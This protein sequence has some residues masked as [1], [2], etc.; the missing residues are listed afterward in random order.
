MGA[1]YMHN[2]AMARLGIVGLA[3]TGK[4]TLFN[5]LTGLAAPAAAHPYSTVEPN[6]GVANV[7]DERLEVAA[8]LEGSAR[9]VHAT[10]E[11]M[12][13]PPLSREGGS[14]AR[15]FM[16]RLRE[17]E[18]L[19]L[20]LRAF[21]DPTVPSAAS[22][23]DPVAQ[24]EELLLEL[25]L[26]DHEVFARRSERLAK[27]AAADPT[28]RSA[29]RAVEEA[30]DRL[31]NGEALRTRE[32]SEE[33]LSAFRDL[34]PLTL[35]PAVWVINI[36]EGAGA[37][38]QLVESVRAVVPSPDVV[39]AISARLE[40]EGA[41]LAPEERAELYEGLGLGEGALARMVQA[42]YEGLGLISFYTVG[43]KESRAW[44]VRAG[45]TA[46]EAAG[47]I[48]SDLERGFIRVE[49]ATLDA[50]LDAGGWDNAK[51]A[52]RVRVEGK[53]Y[54][55]QPDDVLVVRFSV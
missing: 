14:P 31:S 27:E 15:Q 53:G 20:V 34:A 52:G 4:T 9:V 18:A 54:V 32:W 24:A 3:N 22:G 37:P 25:A 10:L 29:G 30:A 12:D 17:M 33:A 39:V 6:V 40:E 42:A 44:T 19:V 50:V 55:V 26:A 11:L 21:T 23:T 13:L 35:K 47:K 38:D 5:A 36:D 45:A 49:V 16:G 2:G 51:K 48:H 46:P 41:R 8:G 7:P 43:P 1:T 28:K